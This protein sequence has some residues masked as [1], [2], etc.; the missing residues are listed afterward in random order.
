MAL[1]RTPTPK[2][3]RDGKTDTPVMDDVTVQDDAVQKPAR[4]KTTDADV[5]DSEERLTAAEWAARQTASHDAVVSAENPDTATSLPGVRPVATDDRPM[6]VHRQ[7][8]VDPATGAV[9]M[10]EHG[11]MP[12]EEWADYEKKNG[13]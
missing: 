6:I 12:V 10:K 2:D 11:P 13:L 7:N 3:V 5:N 8:V 1:G 4:Q 9:T